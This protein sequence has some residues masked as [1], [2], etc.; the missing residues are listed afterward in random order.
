MN[1][2]YSDYMQNSNGRIREFLKNRDDKE[3]SANNLDLDILTEANSAVNNYSVCRINFN[4]FFTEILTFD[5]NG[6]FGKTYSI[7]LREII[8]LINHFNGLFIE[9]SLDGLTVV[10]N[11]NK[12]HSRRKQLFIRNDY[13]K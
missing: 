2:S 11:A 10:F 12:I 1:E 7:L 9:S 13:K 8:S 4:N 3:F 5:E 6:Q